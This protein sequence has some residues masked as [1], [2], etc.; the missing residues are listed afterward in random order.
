PQLVRPKSVRVRPC[1]SY[2]R[3]KPGKSDPNT[4]M[5][6]MAQSAAGDARRSCACKRSSDRWRDHY[7]PEAEGRHEKWTSTPCSR[8]FARLL[9]AER[10]RGKEIPAGHCQRM[11]RTAAECAAGPRVAVHQG[12][13]LR[14]QE[15]G[16]AESAALSRAAVPPLSRRH[17]VLAIHAQCELG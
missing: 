11:A 16:R 2:R 17:S 7:P 12:A 13:S 6:R 1:Q 8:L 4:V 3:G 5:V 10:R 9:G 15:E 14:T